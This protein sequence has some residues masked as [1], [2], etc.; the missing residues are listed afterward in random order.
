M[1]VTFADAEVDWLGYATMRYQPADGPTIYTDPGRYGVLTGEW[2]AA[3]GGRPH[4]RGEAYHANDGQLVVVTHDHHYD[5]DGIRRVAAD[6]A[7]ILVHEAVDAERIAESGE[8]TVTEPEDLPYDVRRVS[9]GDRVT[10]NGATIDAL[11]AHNLPD[12]PNVRTDGRPI[13]PEGRGCG[14]LVEVDGCRWCWTGDTDR[15]DR[16]DALDVDLFFPSIARNYTMD[17]HDAAAIAQTIRPDLVVPIH[18][19]TFDALGADSR[20]FAADVAA[21]GVPVV[22]DES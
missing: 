7:T 21:G 5:D 8:R 18:Y 15:L 2:A 10:V 1:T 11:P 20:A 16:H 22:L 17:R 12:G 14:Y 4:P 13:H 9:V 3:Y 6:D 19:N